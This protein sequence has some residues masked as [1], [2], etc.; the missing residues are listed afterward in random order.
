MA[1]SELIKSFTKIREYVRQFYVYGFRSRNAYHYKSARSYDN[2]HRRL[3][4]W[5][6]EY[7][8]FRQ[9]AGGKIVFLSVDSRACPSNP[10]YVAFKAKSFTDND[11][12]FHFYVMDALADGN[13]MTLRELLEWFD[14][15]YLSNFAQTLAFDESNIRKKLKEYTELG[16]IRMRKEGK[17]VFYSRN[18]SDIDTQS[19]QE[20]VSFFSE[21]D[22]L[23]VVGSYLLDRF[24]NPRQH[25]RFQHH[26]IFRALDSEIVHD[27]LQ[28]MDQGRNVKIE[29]KFQGSGYLGSSVIFPIRICI[30]TQSG[31]QHLLGYHKE[32]KRLVLTRLDHISQVVLGDREP[33]SA[34]YQAMFTDFRKHQ[35]GTSLND[36]N[37]T[38]H[39]EMTVKIA[40]GEAFI[41]RRLQREKRCGQVAQIDDTHYQ[42]TA[43][44][45]DAR[46][47]LPWIRTFMGRITHLSCSNPELLQRFREDVEGMYAM[48]R[49]ASD[50]IS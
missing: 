3:E 30:S 5:L 48:Y 33:E 37:H 38:D 44:V 10:L 40:P 50:D 28:A 49:E 15:E 2:E 26:Y 32:H 24:K 13:E 34:A 46:E 12:A 45:Y 9:E 29:L 27:L 42:F 25:F 47:M 23:G 6:G 11:I 20:A 1:Y 4:S 19:W 7:M 17:Q 21:T 41:L 35:W 14:S 22:P 8:R 16:L 39:I 18:E 36:T 31:R 43:D